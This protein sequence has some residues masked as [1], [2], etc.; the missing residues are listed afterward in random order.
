LWRGENG[1]G[2]RSGFD[3]ATGLGSVNVSA[4]AREAQ[5]AYHHRHL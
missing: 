5:T 4:L 2:A 3:Y 1:R